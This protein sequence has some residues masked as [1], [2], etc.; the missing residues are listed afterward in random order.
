METNRQKKIAGILQQDLAEILQGS[1]R[2][3][4]VKNLLISVSKVQI[5]PDLAVAKA[6]LSVFPASQSKNILEGVRS[7]ESA[8]RLALGRRVKN[9]LRIVPALVFYIDDSLEYIDQID[10]SLS[11]GEDPLSNPS[12]LQHRKKI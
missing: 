10:R 2:K 5:T 11:R 3:E 12:L 1:L 8:I 7:Q 4:G 9:Q 6:Y